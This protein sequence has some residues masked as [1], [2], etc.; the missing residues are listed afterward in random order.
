MVIG[1]DFLFGGRGVGV[2]FG[3]FGRVWCV[4]DLGVDVSTVAGCNI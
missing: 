2:V 4:L 1:M 3:W